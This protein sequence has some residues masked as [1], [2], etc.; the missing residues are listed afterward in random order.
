VDVAVLGG[1]VVGA[2]AALLL[3]REGART[4]LL[5]ARRLGGGVSGNTT[6]KLSSLHGLTY[7]SLRSRVGEEAARAYGEANEEGIARIAALAEELRIDCQL[8]RKPNFTYT[9]SAG[10]REK[11][12]A[13][14]AAA[15]SL[16]LP[17]SYTEQTDLPFLIA[18][19]IRFDDQAEFHPYLYVRGLIE[20]AE[21]AG[22]AVFERTRAVGLAG[23]AIR[24]E[25]GAQVRANRVIIATHAP[26]LDRGLFFARTHPERSYSLA[27]RTSGPVLEGMYLSAGN[28][29]RSLR[30]HPVSGGEL[31]IVAGESHRV[32]EGD[33]PD[34]YRRLEAFARERFDA[35][36]IEYRWSAQDNMPEDGL[37][38]VGRLVPFSDRALVVTGLRKWG[39]AMGTTAAAM[40][41]EMAMGRDHRLAGFFRPERLHPV[42]AIPELASHNAHSGLRFVADRITR[43][44]SLDGIAPGEGRVVGSG[45][46]QAAVY[47]DDDGVIHTRSARCTHLGC[48][49]AWNGAERSW[50]CPCHGSRFG[51]LGDV[52][53]GPATSPL[54]GRDPV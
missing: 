15:S 23:N 32:G 18:A 41:A 36:T 22:C 50:D 21:H 10:D 35:Q 30:S 24:T 39:L 11:I 54:P 4:A 3:A 6:A 37:P 25:A 52:V 33:E 43:R 19:A 34:R 2:T 27:V 46:G 17:A 31:L 29:V 42:A 53:Q 13:E 5:E 8:R 16:G 7:D 51:P 45:L 28:P 26:F 1:G 44:K 38:F 12:E 14:V 47:C 48:I 49:V 9:E 40:V 20:A